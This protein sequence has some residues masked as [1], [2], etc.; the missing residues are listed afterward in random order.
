[1]VEVPLVAQPLPVETIEVA[2]DIDI[3]LLQFGWREFLEAV[4][5]HHREAGVVLRG[6]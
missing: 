3:G 5:H 1:M 4:D 6:R 2:H